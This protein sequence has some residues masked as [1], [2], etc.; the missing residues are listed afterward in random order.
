MISVSNDGDPGVVATI[1]DGP[2]AG[3]SATIEHYD[4]TT[5]AQPDGSNYLA[6]NQPDPTNPTFSTGDG[7]G[8]ESGVCFLA[9]L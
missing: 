3:G 9:G 8:P 2:M 5:L 1:S 4:W 7:F 6:W